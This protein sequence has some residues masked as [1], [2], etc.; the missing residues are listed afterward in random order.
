MALPHRLSVTLRVEL[1]KVSRL[2]PHDNVDFV[3]A[4][5]EPRLRSANRNVFAVLSLTS[6]SPPG[7]F[8]YHFTSCGRC[9]RRSQRV[10][11]SFEIDWNA[12]WLMSQVSGRHKQV[13]SNGRRRW[14]VSGR[15][16]NLLTIA[17]SNC[18]WRPAVYYSESFVSR[19]DPI[20]YSYCAFLI[21][22]RE[23]TL[24]NWI[25]QSTAR[26]LS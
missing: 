7:E 23:S 26:C 18:F 4:Q 24:R 6:C 15:E 16:S 19:L 17:G 20:A 10:C 9:R 5:P 1:S 2:A 3:F 13:L 8:R 25:N 12:L 14:R 22:A 11:R 21:S